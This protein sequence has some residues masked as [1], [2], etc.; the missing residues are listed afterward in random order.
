MAMPPG[1][2]ISYFA[3]IPT[4]EVKQSVAR[5][6]A[7]MRARKDARV[8]AVEPHGIEGSEDAHAAVEEYMGRSTTHNRL[9]KDVLSPAQAP[10]RYEYEEKNTAAYVAAR[11]PAVYGAVHRVLSEVCL[12][13]RTSFEII[14]YIL[15]HQ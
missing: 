4:R 9:S 13:S 8:I 14:T 1:L 2:I 6:T 12:L 3:D 7:N 5:L 10:L 11:M 15:S